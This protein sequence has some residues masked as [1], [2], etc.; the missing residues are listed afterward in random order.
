MIGVVM[1]FGCAVGPDYVKPSAPTPTTYKEMKGWKEAQPRED[2]IRGKWWEMFNDPR[3]N[4]LEEQVNI[5][6]QNVAAAEAQFRQARALVQ[7]ARAAYFPTVSAG[8]SY[9]R[10][11]SSSNTVSGSSSSGYISDYLLSFDASWEPDIWGK[12]RRS[13]ESGEANAQASAADL[14]SARLS[15]QA[16]LAQDYFQLQ[17]LDAQKQLLDTTVIAYQKFLDLTMNRYA[18][19]VASRADVLQAQTQLKTTQAQAIDIGVQRAQTEHAIALL[20]G[21]PA[22]D[23]SIPVMQLAADLPPIPVGVPSDLLE[24][25]PDVAG[26]ERRMAAANAQI[27][28]A[29]AAY[30]PSITLG[31]SGG[32]QSSGSAEWLTWPSRFWSVGPSILQT[33]FDGGLIKAQTEQAR[34]AY[35]ANVASYRQAVLTG[36]QEVEDNLAAL[37]ILEEESAVQDEAVTAAQQS[38]MVTTNQYKAGTASALDVI[39]TQITELNNK[40]TAISITGSRLTASVLL[41]KALGGG[42]SAEALQPAT[43]NHSHGPGNDDKLPIG[44]PEKGMTMETK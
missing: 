39:I 10:S 14:E 32:Y 1:L 43:D 21:K 13:V 15:A 18:S 25:R 9:T 11:R 19:G 12:V 31:A 5:S 20:V 41:I 2:V 4:A 42:W 16:E 24:R 6:N 3:L 37:R 35:D 40:R 30:Y 28:V 7:A 26:A 27:G 38:V 36:F 8:P 44:I 34:A 33:V 29:Q 23:F 22:S 17:D